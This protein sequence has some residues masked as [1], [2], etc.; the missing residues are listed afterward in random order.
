[1]G[2][3]KRQALEQGDTCQ[4]PFTEASW[5]GWVTPGEDIKCWFKGGDWGSGG[6]G[7]K[8][9]P[10]AVACGQAETLSVCI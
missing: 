9:A 2:S 8:G 4:D 10:D 3:T 1:M 6:D 7:G 5:K